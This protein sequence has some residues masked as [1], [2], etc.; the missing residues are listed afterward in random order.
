MLQESNL[1]GP[2]RL[3][4][5]LKEAD[6]DFKTYAKALPIKLHAPRAASNK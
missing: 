1:I 2:E 3:A 4:E 5:L 6:P